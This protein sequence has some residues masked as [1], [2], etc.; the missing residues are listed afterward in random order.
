MSRLISKV[1]PVVVIL[2]V[3]MSSSAALM[4]AEKEEP[5]YV[6]IIWH[7]H[8][9]FYEDFE[10]KSFMPWVRLHAAKDYFKMAW[11]SELCPEVHT[12]ID[13]TGSL[14]IQLQDL[15]SGRAI[16]QR[17]VIS[18]KL[19]KGEP[20]TMDEKWLMLQ[21]P[22]GFFDINWNNIVYKYDR[23]LEL[24]EKRDQAFK[25]YGALPG[26]AK[27][28]N[29]TNYFT[30]QDFL[31]LAVMFNLYWMNPLVV[32]KMYPDL[33]SIWD[34]GKYRSED[35][36]Y[37]PFTRD[38]LAKILNAHIDQ[39][40]KTIDEHKKLQEMGIIEVITTPY[41]HPLSPL[42]VDFGWEDDLRIQVR[43]G[44]EIYEKLFG[45]KPYGMW[46]PEE[47]LNEKVLEVFSDYNITW[48]I[49]DP[50]VAAYAD[51]TFLQGGKPNYYKI[52]TPYYVD[53]G[54]GKRIYVFFRDWVL[55]DKVGFQYSGWS[56]DSAVNDFVNTILSVKDQVGGGKILVIAL[57]G[58]NAWEHYPNDATDF[59]T[60][61]YEKLSD[62]QSKGLIKTVTI[63]EYLEKYGGKDKAIEFPSSEVSVL[64]LSGKDI[65]SISGYEN[66]PRKTLVQKFPEGSWAGGDLST[67]IGELQEN[68][69]WMYLKWTRDVLYNYVISKGWSWTDVK[70]WDEGAKRALEALLRAEG[71]DW[72]WWYGSDQN[73]GNDKGFDQL[74][75]YYLRS[76]F[77]S[78]GLKP[79][80]YTLT[81]FFP[82]GS[83][84]GFAYPLREDSG[85]VS[86]KINGVID[87]V[88]WHNAT[89]YLC[90]GVISEMLLGTDESAVYVGIKFSKDV[91]EYGIVIDISKKMPEKTNLLDYYSLSP[92][93]AVEYSIVDGNVYKASTL[94]SPGNYG[95]YNE[96]WEKVGSIEVSKT[97]TGFEAKIPYDIIGVSGKTEIYVR[98]S[99]KVNDTFYLAPAEYP[100]KTFSRTAV[101]L[102]PVFVYDDPEGDDKGPGTYTYP[103]NDVFVDG[104]F[105]ILRFE[106]YDLGESIEFVFKFKE[107]GDNPWNGPNGLSLQIIE[108]YIDMKE[109]EGA[110][111][112][113]E[114][115]NVEIAEQDAWE[116]AIRVAGW[117]YGNVIWL[118]DKTKV[119]KALT[120]YADDNANEVY[121]IMPKTIKL[122]N[123]SVIKID[124][125]KDTW[126]YVV[127]IGSQDG[128]GVDYWR[129][130]RIEAEEWAVGGADPQ[131]IIAG[132]VPRVMDMLSP[133]WTTQEEMLTSYNVT[134]GEKAKVY[135]VGLH[136][137]PPLT[138]SPSPTP[139][140][141]LSTGAI[142]GIVIAVIVIIGVGAYFAMRRR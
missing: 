70:S 117:D 45:T 56:A 102:K 38:D 101:S 106:V 21:V 86:P 127:L 80:E 125:P 120:I 95:S 91:E 135:G 77:K 110:T 37:K 54:N 94:G 44:I 63:R 87:D 24:K 108:V 22:G 66:L 39:V 71:S 83:P 48:T 47:A 72:F 113:S 78:I 64:D 55:S 99:V 103:K 97:S 81:E 58:E 67:W 34:K 57:D 126:E 82:D 137:E 139:A 140:G 19:A 141:G 29:I 4:K 41:T 130:V 138:P 30:A 128:Y 129:P 116:I 107:L 20:L 114:G 17:Y 90:E 25:L 6:A 89:E 11:L 32:Q 62:L 122:P 105:D 124:G 3:L 131:A 109:G 46:P 133:P 111:W 119:E 100:A 59:L 9:P 31:D 76:V 88:E 51:P 35:P 104:A 84:Y 33:W 40:F 93:F 49:T 43:K 115:S 8:Q 85:P 12:T 61:L 60:K 2:I 118:Q 50:R 7:Q 92:G 42:L 36:N 5:L 26:K 75:K 123:G 18:E 52:T 65:Y 28:E 136:A 27:I 73:S 69:G 98:V 1:F 79:P 142:V 16:D 132:V 23:Y 74:F 13:L 15:M 14:L 96:S 134:T 121:V 112:A 68:R 53:F 10:G